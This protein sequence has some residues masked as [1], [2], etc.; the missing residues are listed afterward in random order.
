MA[1][2]SKQEAFTLGVFEGLSAS[3]AY[4]RAY[5]AGAMLPATINRDASALLNHPKVAARLAELR[6]TVRERSVVTVERVIEEYARIAFADMRRFATVGSGGITLKNSSEWTDDDAAAVSELG[7][8]IS[9]EGGSVRFKLHS[10]TAALDSLAKTL[11][12][13]ADDKPEGPRHLH[14]HGLNEA[15]LRALA[16]GF[17]S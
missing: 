14:L 8:T 12:M 5:S 11:G 9:K 16:S 13:F 10:K 7:E 6:T 15:E 2:T 1:L 3:E 17:G 4:R